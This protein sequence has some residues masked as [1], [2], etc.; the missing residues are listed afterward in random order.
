MTEKIIIWLFYGSFLG[1]TSVLL[2]HFFFYRIQ[3]LITSKRSIAK[4]KKTISQKSECKDSPE[5]KPQ[6]SRGEEHEKK[7]KAS[8]S[9]FIPREVITMMR[10]AETLLARKEYD[11]A[12]KILIK[13]LAF[14]EDNLSASSHLA[15]AVLQTGEFRKAENLFKKVIEKKPKDPGI[16]TNYALSIFEQKNESRI[17]D[18]I[19]A[20]KLATEIDSNNAHRYSNLGQSYFFAG[21]IPSAI[22]AFE[23]AVRLQPKNIEFQFFLADSLLLLDKYT[24]AKTVFSRILD[25]SPLNKDAQEEIKNIEKMGY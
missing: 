14:D 11:E 25:I 24:E 12:I 21:D 23:Q 20:L 9:D 15:Y 6:E 2:W 1:L 8:D 22:L 17:Q 18:S 5:P 19:N 16:L 3:R 10:Q 7:K 4:K 13:V